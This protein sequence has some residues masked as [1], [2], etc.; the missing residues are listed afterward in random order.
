MIGEDIMGKIFS[1]M[2][3]KDESVAKGVLGGKVREH[4]TQVSRMFAVLTSNVL[5]RT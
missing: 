3:A 2:G 1:C 5:G 4:A